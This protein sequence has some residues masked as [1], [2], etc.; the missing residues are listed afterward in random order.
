M[1]SSTVQST[2]FIIPS[3]MYIDSACLTTYIANFAYMEWDE[4]GIQNVL[5][6]ICIPEWWFTYAMIASLMTI[7]KWAYLCLPFPQFVSA[8]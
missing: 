2:V 4:H 6:V 7:M 1:N 3:S 8:I 5:L